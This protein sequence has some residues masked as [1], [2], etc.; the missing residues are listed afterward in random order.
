[1]E[2]PYYCHFV[3][4]LESPG[5]DVESREGEERQRVLD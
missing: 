2:N 1:M 4:T 5:T 3:Q